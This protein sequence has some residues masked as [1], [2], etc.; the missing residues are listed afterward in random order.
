MKLD[1]TRLGEPLSH[2]GTNVIHP[3]LGRGE[4]NA[5]ARKRKRKKRLLTS[6]QLSCSQHNHPEP[7]AVINA[8]PPQ[9]VPFSASDHFCAPKRQRTGDEHGQNLETNHSEVGAAPASI[10]LGI[11]LPQLGKRPCSVRSAEHAVGPIQKVDVGGE[12]RARRRWIVRGVHEEAV[13][14]KGAFED[15]VDEG[16]EEVP[17]EEDT[18]FCAAVAW[19][20]A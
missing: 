5:E 2:S 6:V 16:V 12:K 3:A 18:G 4:V 17:D 15:K 19:Q 9:V 20:S 1:V 8:F 7:L 13:P 11:F 14:E 10:G